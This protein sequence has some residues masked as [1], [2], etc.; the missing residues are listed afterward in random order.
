[1]KIEVSKIKDKEIFLAQDIPAQSWDLDSF[2]VKFI[3]HIHLDCK[4]L[5]VSNEIIVNARVSTHR[6]IVCSRCL[7]NSQQNI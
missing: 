3:N 6:D 1:M 5:R 4:F 7:G 2:D